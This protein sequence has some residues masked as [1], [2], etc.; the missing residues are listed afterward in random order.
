MSN[1]AISDSL[2]KNLKSNQNL[3]T[4][5]LTIHQRNDEIHHQQSVPSFLDKNIY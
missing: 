5:P 4:L 3:K 1:F 2:I